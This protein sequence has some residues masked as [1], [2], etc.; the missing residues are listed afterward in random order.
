V[1]ATDERTAVVI[2]DDGDVREVIETILGEA[3]FT[4]TLAGTGAEGIDLVT[5]LA[6]AIT[7]LDVNMPGMDGFETL[8][9]IREVSATRII[10]ISARFDET[11]VVRGLS[12]GADDF[13][14]KPFRTGELRARIDAVVRRGPLELVPAPA[15]ISWLERDGLRLDPERR[16]V[17]ADGRP[18]ALTR[19]EFDLL[20]VLMQPGDR[21]HTKAELIHELRGGGYATVGYVTGADKRSLEVHVANVRKKLGRTASGGD[22]I[23]TVRG[24]GYRLTTGPA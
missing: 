22:R 1:T 3:G 15:T 23:E 20:A 6:P 10:M 19:S 2:D 14:A 16:L 9:H 13:L 4:V 11:D 17:E 7:T 24:V 18:V 8:Q 12:A 5:A 21:V